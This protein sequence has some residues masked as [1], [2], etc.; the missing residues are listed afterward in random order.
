[1]VDFLRVSGSMDDR[2]IE[3]VDHLHEH[4]VDP[5]VMQRGRYMPPS[6]PGYS[7]TMHPASLDEYAFPN[8]SAWALQASPSR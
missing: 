4:F 8:G 1:M 3:Y 5:V 7:S 6:A 2:L